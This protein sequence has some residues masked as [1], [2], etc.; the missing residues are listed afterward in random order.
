MRGTRRPEQN[1]LL[2]TYNKGS[3]V[4]NVLFEMR[5]AAFIHINP[6]AGKFRTIT[7]ERSPNK[8]HVPCGITAEMNTI[9][10]I[11][12]ITSSLILSGCAKIHLSD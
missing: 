6:N 12:V 10:Q 3:V 1:I 2:G 11:Y 8:L 9:L 5:G 7:H 4:C